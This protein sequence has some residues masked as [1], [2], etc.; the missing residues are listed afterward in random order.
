ME[1]LDDARVLP[2]LDRAD[3]DGFAMG[4]PSFPDRPPAWLKPTIRGASD[5]LSALVGQDTKVTWR[6]DPEASAALFQ[7]QAKLLLDAGHPDVRVEWVSSAGT[8]G[9][10]RDALRYAPRVD[11]AL[12][13]FN[14]NPGP[15]DFS[16]D[17]MSPELR[18]WFEGLIPNPN[19]RCLVAVEVVFSGSAK[20]VLGDILNASVLGR[21]GLVVCHP[22][23]L[24]RAKRNREY[25]ASLANVGKL[26]KLFRNV[27]VMSVDEFLNGFDPAPT[28][29]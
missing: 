17:Q 4:I 14:T 15:G 21:Y 20:H 19:P 26:P 25:L 6:G 12:G 28:L 13:P 22:S 29:D 16:D 11:I 5:T 1:E 9:L 24:A 27:R 7:A 8:D 23:K 10:G 2:A 18:G 3:F